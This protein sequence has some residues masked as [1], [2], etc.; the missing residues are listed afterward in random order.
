MVPSAPST[1]DT[2]TNSLRPISE[3]MRTGTSAVTDFAAS[4]GRPAQ[5]RITGA[6]KAWKVKIAE[7][8]KPGSTTTGFLSATARQSGLPG[9]SATPC[10][11]MPG[12]PSCETMRCERSPAPFEVPPLKITMSHSDKARRIAASRIFSSSANAPNETGCP[13]ASVTAAATM[14]PLLS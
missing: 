4:G 9:L 14:A 5:A 8:G 2:S 12:A 1:S 7:V 10:T 11:R 3:A 6:T 13:P